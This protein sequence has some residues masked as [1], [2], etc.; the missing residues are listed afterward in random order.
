MSNNEKGFDGVAVMYL[1][2]VFLDPNVKDPSKIA[3]RECAIKVMRDIEDGKSFSIVC[4][5]FAKIEI[6]S[7]DYAGPLVL[8]IEE[9]NNVKDN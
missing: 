5:N 1:P 4:P 6:F 3:M 8:P 2:P 7:R 9:N